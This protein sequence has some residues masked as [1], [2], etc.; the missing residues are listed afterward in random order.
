MKLPENMSNIV[1][2]T[3]KGQ[4]DEEGRPHGHG[5][6]EYYTKTEKKYKYEGHFEHGVRSGY[7]VF[8]ETIQYIREYE[9]WEWVQMGDY[10]STGRLIHPN[11]KPGPYREVI[12]CW[13]ERFRG[14]WKNDDAV[15]NLKGRKYTDWKF[16][17]LEDDTILND[18][19]A[20]TKEK[21]SLLDKLRDN[22]NL[23]F[24]TTE[25]AADPKTAIAEAERE[26][27]RFS[28]SILWTEQLGSFYESEG[29]R[30]KAIKAYEKCIING[31]YAPIYDLALMYLDD[32]EGYSET[33]MEIGRQLG[34]PDQI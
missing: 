27:S 22:R 18:L 33:L 21:G 9:P 11:T 30:D 13:D 28:G 24:G 23:F 31:Y 5:I 14:W 25:V 10:D 2:K 12:N 20:Q 29:E 34:V 16:D 3:Y 15:H 7:G 19:T 26:A 8:H 6:M 1:G 32:D 17:I 4:K